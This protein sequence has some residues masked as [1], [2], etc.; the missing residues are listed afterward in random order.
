MKVDEVPQD[1]NK[2]FRGYGTKAV[3]AVDK[4]GRYTK[5][6]YNGWEAE[7]V[8][9]RDALAD[10]DQKAERAKTRVLRGEISPIEY[11]YNRRYMDL[12]ALAQAMGLPKWR[13]KRHLKPKVFNHLGEK[14]L[15]QYADVFRI[16]VS[17]LKNFKENI[18]IDP[19]D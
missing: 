7:E 16:N 1:N 13:V 5:I 2:T 3:Y 8:V 14:R 15:K 10:F 17:D 19:D 6:P 4:T 18:G 9:L 11:Y 12:P